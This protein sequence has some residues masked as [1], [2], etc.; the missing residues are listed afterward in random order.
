MADKTPVRVVFDSGGTATGLGEFQTGETV[1]VANGGT[2]LSSLGSALQTLRVNAA[3]NAFEFAAAGGDLDI[4]GDDS[5]SMVVAL[6]SQTLQ[7]SGDNSITTSTSSSQTLSITLDN[8]IFVNSIASNDST[9]IQINDAVNVS[10]ALSVGGTLDVNTIASSDSSGVFINDSLFVSGDIKAEG[11]TAVVF[12]DKVAVNEIIPDDSSAVQISVLDVHNIINSTSSFIQIG[13]GLNVNGSIQTNGSVTAGTSF[14]IG[15]ADINETDLEKLD[16]ITNGAGLA[17]KALV[18]DGSADV[19][20]GLRNLTASGTI[21]AS[22][23]DTN[24]LQ[25]TDSTAIQVN[26]GLNVSGTLSVNSIDT[27]TISSTDSSGVFINDSLFVSG[28]IKAEGSTAVVFK[29]KV[30][31]NEIIPDDSSA[32]QISNLDVNVILN[33]SSSAIQINE[34]VNMSGALSVGGALD[35]NTISSTDSTGV[36]INDTLYVSGSILGEGS[37]AVSFGGERVTGVANPSNDDDVVNLSYFN[38]N[39]AQNGFPNST[40]GSFP[41]T[42]SADSS[43]TDF[44]DGEDF[45]GQSASVDA[46]N[47]SLVTLYDCM[48]PI[49]SLTTT[50]FGASETHVGA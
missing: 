33:S 9:A 18:L 21:T 45:V 39:S 28:D 8:D 17:N 24:V 35:V 1:P 27:N 23:V 4:R 2:G 47:V 25:S 26:E 32:V 36:L 19:A 13:E 6:A 14:I 15:D 49:G 29:D 37:T 5:T 31:V 41:L 7:I 11:S 42:S 40:V 44:N 38:D 30:A 50:D 43:A 34:A 10:G 46:F 3:G 12:K 16:G 48:E 20:S 22:T